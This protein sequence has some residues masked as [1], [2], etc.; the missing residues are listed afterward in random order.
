MTSE[1]TS[2]W[3]HWGLTTGASFDRKATGNSQISNFVSIGSITPVRYTGVPINFSWSD[4][5]PTSTVTGT[6]SGIFTYNVGNGFQLTVPADTTDRTLKLYVGL[7]KAQGRLEVALSDGSASPYVDTS[8]VNQTGASNTVF[9]LKYRAGG[10][11]QSLTVRWTLQ[12]SWDTAANL[13]LAVRDS[14]R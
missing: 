4:G 10:N 14:C 5:T 3:A 12:A 13:T 9:T 6:N 7:Y 1:G 11:G 2:D 8:L